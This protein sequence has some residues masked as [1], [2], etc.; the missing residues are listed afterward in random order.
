MTDPDPLLEVD[1]LRVHFPVSDGW[2]ARDD[3]V[4]RAV[5]GI[6][7]ELQRGEVLAVVGESGCG[8]TTLGRAVV[9]LAEP[10]SGSIKFGGKEIDK[11]T[12]E[13]RANYRR[14][15]QMVFQDPFD[16]MNPRKTAFQIVS[17]ALKFNN[18][19]PKA[20]FVEVLDK[21]VG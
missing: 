7:L 12:G 6:S 20:K 14:Q 21:L 4:V 5:D 18:I 15:V 3:R 17:Q 19:V 2:A 13:D 11:L 10:T 16:S 9:G 1:D 8:K